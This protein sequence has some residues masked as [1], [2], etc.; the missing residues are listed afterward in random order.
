MRFADHNHT[1]RRCAFTLVE[2]LVVV[3]IVAILTALLLPALASARESARRVHCASNLRQLGAAT[4][5]LAHNNRGRFRLAH[6]GLPESH[7]DVASYTDPRLLSLGADHLSWLSTHMVRRY[8]REAGVDVMSFT[9]PTRAE[10]FLRRDREHAG[11][12]RTGYFTM[13]GRPDNRF[14]YVQGRRFRSP[15]RPSDPARL[16]LATD[17]LEQGTIIGTAGDIQTSAPH[18]VR[19][20]VAGPPHKTPAELG[21]RGANAAF[22]DGSVVFVPQSELKAHASHGAGH[23]VGYWPELPPDLRR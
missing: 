10:D 6:V 15:L 23:I 16:V 19:G 17:I 7:A 22:L 21:S 11:F 2:L 8:Q 5:I 20:L 12:L 1:P 13:A 9:C 18:G 3:A 14:P 4:F